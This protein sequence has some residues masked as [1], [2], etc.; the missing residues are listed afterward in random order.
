MGNAGCGTLRK[1]DDASAQIR[2]LLVSRTE[3]AELAND[4]NAPN[5]RLWSNLG[6]DGIPNVRTYQGRGKRSGVSIRTDQQKYVYGIPIYLIRA[7]T[8]NLS[9]VTPY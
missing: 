1:L 4:P 6:N 3:I 7:T 8:T 5:R 2:R 9:A